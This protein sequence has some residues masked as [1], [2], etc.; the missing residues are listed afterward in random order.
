M[1]AFAFATAHDLAPSEEALDTPLSPPDL[2]NEPG[3][4]TGRSVTYPD[5]THTRRPDPAFRTHHVS[6]LLA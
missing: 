6:T 2:S 3:S 5:G 4:A 1:F